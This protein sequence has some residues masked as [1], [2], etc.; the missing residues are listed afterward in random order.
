MDDR[1][2]LT[3]LFSDLGPILTPDAIIEDEDADGVVAGWT[4]MLSEGVAV[5]AVA[6]R[7][8]RVLAFSTVIAPPP[9]E[10]RGEILFQL[11]HVGYRWREM[12]GVR[13]A[14][15]PDGEA[16]LRYE[17]P[18]DAMDVQKLTEIIQRLAAN[19]SGLADVFDS[20]GAARGAPAPE[21]APG[22]MGV[23]PI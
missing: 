18:Y 21:G 16:V 12:G 22:A 23:I 6:L 5:Q 11:L 3:A 19:R 13:V 2:R 4:V 8:S 10:E 15:T 20:V 17:Y 14:M 9:D 7:E 1:E